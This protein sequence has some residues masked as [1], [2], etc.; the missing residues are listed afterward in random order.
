MTLSHNSQRRSK[1]SSRK[2]PSYSKRT[3]KLGGDQYATTPSASSA[4]TPLTVSDITSMVKGGTASAAKIAPSMLTASYLKGMSESKKAEL[5]KADEL[6]G[7]FVS[8]QGLETTK[9]SNLAGLIINYDDGNFPALGTKAPANDP[10]EGDQDRSN[11]HKEA[12]EAVLPEAFREIQAALGALGGPAGGGLEITKS[13]GLAVSAEAMLKMGKL[14]HQL[15]PELHLKE[16]TADVAKYGQDGRG[17]A[18]TTKYQ[19]LG[20]AAPCDQAVMNCLTSVGS[21]T[22]ALINYESGQTQKITN[23]LSSILTWKSEV[24]P[25]TKNWLNMPAD[26]VPM[27][28]ELDPDMPK[29]HGFALPAQ[30]ISMDAAVDIGKNIGVYTKWYLG[31]VGLEE[32]EYYEAYEKEMKSLDTTTAQ[33]AVGRGLLSSATADAELSGDTG[34]IWTANELKGLADGHST[35]ANWMVGLM[36]ADVASWVTQADPWI[37]PP[38]YACGTNGFCHGVKHVMINPAGIGPNASVDLPGAINNA[39]HGH[40][41]DWGS[42]IGWERQAKPME[43]AALEAGQFA[44]AI[45]ADAAI[46]QYKTGNPAELELDH[47]LSTYSATKL[48]SLEKYA[49]AMEQ[50]WEKM[51]SSGDPGQIGSKVWTQSTVGGSEGETPPSSASAAPVRFADAE[52]ASWKGITGMLTAAVNAIKSDPSLEADQ[53]AVNRA[54]SAATTKML[55]AFE[56]GGATYYATSDVANMVDEHE[57]LTENAENVW[58]YL[59]PIM[60][61]KAKQEGE[62]TAKNIEKARH[63]V[64]HQFGVKVGILGAEIAVALAAIPWTFGATAIAAGLDAGKIVTDHNKENSQLGRLDNIVQ[65]LVD[66]F[67]SWYST[68]KSIY[69]NV[70]KPGTWDGGGSTKPLGGPAPPPPPPSSMVIPGS[71]QLRSDLGYPASAAPSGGGDLISMLPS[72]GLSSPGSSS[73]DTQSTQYAGAAQGLAAGDW[74]ALRRSA[75]SA[76]LANMTTYDK[77]L[78]AGKTTL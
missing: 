11:V 42:G 64:I 54:K 65:T 46:A 49:G 3:P 4:S 67:P 50:G 61:E 37:D 13:G 30:H 21:Q 1:A 48:A 57:K 52:L 77:Y 8:G 45:G 6:I 12:S 47:L 75:E 18:M 36:G 20:Y 59:T 68:I 2:I 17:L 38:D 26:Q 66:E 9:D 31:T 16:L 55:N 56:H 72:G 10:G 7:S 74:R 58:N 28:N 25:G 24:K 14:I 76:A 19:G 23:N 15:A 40:A 32:E 35:Q 27:V 53:T 34:G 73:S 71:A 63:S 43:E 39:V 33:S 29:Q 62:K 5:S 41:N 60:Q 51:A 78:Q 44:R 22:A 70:G 69:P